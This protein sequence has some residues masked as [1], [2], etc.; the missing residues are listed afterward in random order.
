MLFVVTNQ[1][2][3]WPSLLSAIP[4]YG[5]RQPDC[6]WLLLAP[7]VPGLIG[8]DKGGGGNRERETE[9]SVSSHVKG[10]RSHGPQRG[11][12]L[13]SGHWVLDKGGTEPHVTRAFPGRE[14]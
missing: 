10:L 6:I 7:E 4:A 5:Y 13:Q 2:T 9:P 1:V 12:Q 8:S 14:T 3:L 11:C